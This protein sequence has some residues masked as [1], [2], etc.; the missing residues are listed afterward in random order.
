MLSRWASSTTRTLLAALLHSR[1]R[2]I[3]DTLADLLISTVHRINARA[4]K[5]VTEQLVAEFRRVAGKENILF[6]LAEAAVDHPD[7]TVR[8]AL[9]PVVGEPTLRHLVAE[10]KSSGPTYQ[11]TVKTTLKASYTNHYRRGLIKLLEVLRFQSNN[12]T[13]RPVV[14]ALDLIGRYA[15]TGNL[16]YY[17]LDEHVPEHNGI[18]D[19]WRE[20]VFRADTR[21]RRRAVRT[22]YEICT[23]QALRDRLRCKE[24]W[25][26]GADRWRNPDEDLP[27]DFEDRRVEHYA[28]LRKPLDPTA[29][30]DEIRTEMRAA[31]S[32]LDDAV[33]ALPWL[34]ISDRKAGAIQLSPLS[35]APEPRNLRRLKQEIGR[36]WRAVPLIDMLKEAV[37]RTDCLTA[38][39]S[40]AR[41]TSLDAGDLAERL[42]LAVHAYG[43]N[44]GI[45]AVT[46][47]ETGHSEDDVR[48]VRRRFLTA[49]VARNMAIEIANATFAAREQ[50]VWGA[51]STSVA[52]DSTH[53]GAFDQNIF[54]EW[55]SR[56]GGRG[57]LIYWHVEKKS[58]AIHSQLIAC[59]ASEVAAMVEGAMRHGTSMNVEANYVDSHGQSEIGF[60]DHPVARVRSA[61]PDQTDQPSEDVPAGRG[62]ARGVPGAH[63]GNDPA[64]P[65]GPDRP[66]VRPDGQ[67]RHR[68]PAGHRLH[69]G[70][71]APFHPQRDPPHLPGHART[72]PGAEDHLRRPLP[73]RPRPAAGDQRGS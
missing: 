54:T 33:P 43:T 62:R 37:L 26:V 71:P 40:V 42:L 68:D 31:L 32:E 73:T 57:V 3:T 70:D 30:L 22:V 48:Y 4:E 16:Q 51:S 67:V 11:R 35:A 24:I 10:Y 25:V 47:G 1:E 36:R 49:D 66:A 2:E 55:H 8:T 53:V 41:G 9:F 5:K 21:G 60:W 59:T 13:H 45:R 72:R 6:R 18:S 44:A 69:G 39:T 29:F 61:T 17:P 20:L 50:D 23:F 58:V 56:Y 65:L 63:A 64:D 14:G 15:R 46:A 52:S 34:T 27:A 38:V 19:A 28:A 7:D 12:T